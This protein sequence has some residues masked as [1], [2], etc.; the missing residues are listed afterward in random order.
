MERNVDKDARRIRQA[1]I[2]EA[3]YRLL[4]ENGYGATSMLRIA[5]TAKASNET[6]YRWYGDKDGLIK[7]MVRANAAETKRMLADAIARGNDPWTTLQDVAPVFLRMLLG[8]RAILLNQA[9]AADP[10]GVL[11]AMIS[12]GGRNEVMPLLSRLLERVCAGTACNP[13]DAGEWFIGLLVGDLQI[14]RIINER[15]ALS[16]EEIME[17]CGKSLKALHRLIGDR[18]S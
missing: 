6:L 5:K 4:D 9:A 16:E 13:K 2:F 17:R 12:A 3:A 7:E 18:P 10:S 15:A 14:R 11:G 8:E 1:E